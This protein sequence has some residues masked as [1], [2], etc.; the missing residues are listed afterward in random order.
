MTTKK[1]KEKICIPFEVA[2]LV[3]LHKYHVDT[4][5]KMKNGEMQETEYRDIETTVKRMR[6]VE[7]QITWNLHK[8]C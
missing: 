2:K 5:N 6:Q 3:E 8:Y 1:K 7:N 4:Y